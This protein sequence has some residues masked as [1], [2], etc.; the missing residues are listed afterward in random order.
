M[1]EPVS[2]GSAFASSLGGGLGGIAASGIGSLI[3]FGLN[4]AAASKSWDRQKNLMTRGPSYVREGLIAAGIN[5][6]LAA[7]SIGPGSAKAPQA[8][9]IGAPN[10]AQAAMMGSQMRLQH[11]QSRK[12]DITS[13]LE[14][15]TLDEA[16]KRRSYLLANPHLVEGGV[17]NEIAPNTPTS[18]AF[19]AAIYGTTQDNLEMKIPFRAPQPGQSGWRSLIPRNTRIPR[20]K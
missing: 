10:T 16:L 7:G 12:L 1:A 19:R 20:A 3:G 2:A 13:A 15:S 14:E 18:A 6:I 9:G 4:A 5:P 11:S 17:I 8:S